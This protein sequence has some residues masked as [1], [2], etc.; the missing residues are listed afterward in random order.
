MCIVRGPHDATFY[1]IL[2][3]LNDELDHLLLTG[4]KGYS[5]FDGVGHKLGG[6]SGW[7]IS[8]LDIKN[9]TLAAAEQRRQVQRIML[10]TGGV[11]LGG[12]TPNPLEKSSTPK[13]MAARA[14][15]R[16]LCDQ[17]W[18]GGLQEESAD[19]NTNNDPQSSTVI[20]LDDDNDMPNMNTSGKKRG[21]D[22]D[23]QDQ[24][25]LTKRP[26]STWI[27]AL[28]TF[29][30]QGL[31]LACAMCLSERTHPVDT[32]DSNNSWTCPRCTLLNNMDITTCDAC[33]FNKV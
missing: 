14:A 6:P 2:D 8:T 32:T 4:Q 22:D 28:C 26:H 30:N 20:V 29:E 5:A 1:K 7:P 25:I 15:E 13:Q 17:K 12:A 3:E 19:N 27:C 9:R 23:D 33:N 31:V 11:R 10:P 21:R 16:R 24:G 18:C